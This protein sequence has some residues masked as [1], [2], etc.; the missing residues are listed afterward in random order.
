[1]PYEQFRR[2]IVAKNQL[3][4]MVLHLNAKLERE[5]EEHKREMAVMRGMLADT[6]VAFT[7][8]AAHA[9]AAEVRADELTQ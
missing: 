7:L 2:A 1:V 6:R 4:K 9:V 5:R 3:A 8:A